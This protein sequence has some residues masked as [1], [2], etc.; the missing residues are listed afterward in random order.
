MTEPLGNDA[1]AVTCIMVCHL[2]FPLSSL[3]P[4][5]ALGGTTSPAPT[6]IPTPPPLSFFFSVAFLNIVDVNTEWQ[7]ACSTPGCHPQNFGFRGPRGIAFGWSKSQCHIRAKD[8][9]NKFILGL[10][11][12]VPLDLPPTPAYLLLRPISP[13]TRRSTLTIAALSAVAPTRLKATVLPEIPHSS[14]LSIIT[15]LTS[16][17]MSNDD[18]DDDEHVSLASASSGRNIFSASALT[19]LRLSNHPLPHYSP[20][21]SR[22]PFPAA[23][24]L[25]SL[26]SS[27]IAAPPSSFPC[28][29]GFG[30]SGKPTHLLDAKPCRRRRRSY[31]HRTDGN[32]SHARPYPTFHIHAQLAQRYLD[33]AY[34]CLLST[35][36]NTTADATFTAR[37]PRA[38]TSAINADSPPPTLFF[39]GAHWFTRLFFTLVRTPI[40]AH[41]APSRQRARFRIPPAFT[42]PCI[43]RLWAAA[44]SGKALVL[45]TRM[46]SNEETKE[47]AASSRGANQSMFKWVESPKKGGSPK[48][49]IQTSSM[50][51]IA[52][53]LGPN[54]NIPV[55]D[56]RDREFDFAS[57][58]ATLEHSLPLWQG[59]EIPV[60]AFIVAG[61]SMHS[62]MGKAQGIE[63]KVLHVSNNIL[64]VIVCGVP[65]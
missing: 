59:G 26:S 47:A 51:N 58:L 34:N 13:R 2:I 28:A 33:L 63:D 23:H 6:P 62:Y 36:T 15:S 20:S 40:A 50:T 11:N 38:S 46:S 54:D 57:G 17:L 44:M 21:H 42:L 64:W 41:H 12:I 37:T 1:E 43:C 27:A 52:M 3:L 9:F 8:I 10:R 16:A 30:C 53:T 56:A 19:V 55:Y 7:L 61:Y 25:R 22:L 49:P 60:G 45:T 32:F 48:K 39:R 14:H 65:A 35:H 5:D 29:T 4:T 24:H 31:R 18:D